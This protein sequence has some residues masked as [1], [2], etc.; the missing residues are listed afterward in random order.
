MN[1]R[2]VAQVFDDL[3]NPLVITGDSHIQLFPSTRLFLSLIQSVW[4]YS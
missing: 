3:G 4:R 2:G 1:M